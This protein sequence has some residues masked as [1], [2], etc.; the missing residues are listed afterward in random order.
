MRGKTIGENLMIAVV[1]VEA[2][3]IHVDMIGTLGM[4]TT[5]LSARGMYLA[6][7]VIQGMAIVLIVEE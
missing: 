3:L 5:D 1:M 4:I 7:A 6:L 2:V